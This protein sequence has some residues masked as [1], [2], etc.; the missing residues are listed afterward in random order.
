MKT[1]IKYVGINGGNVKK[2][3]SFGTAYETSKEIAWNYLFGNS[4]TIV[5][6]EK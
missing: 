2:E 4:R 6:K 3:I 5:T 1:I